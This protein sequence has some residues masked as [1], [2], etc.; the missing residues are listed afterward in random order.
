MVSSLTL[1]FIHLR[2]TEILNCNDLFG[3][4]SVVFFADFLQLSPVKSNQP[5]MPVMFHEAKQRFDAIASVDVWKAF[6]Y[7]ELTINM[8]QN[9]DSQYADLL[10]SLHVGR[11]D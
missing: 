10:S 4:I 5:F 11:P 9:G 8:H 6:E 3:G 1:L 2:L 7:D